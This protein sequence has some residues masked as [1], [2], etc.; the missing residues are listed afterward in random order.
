MTSR[1]FEQLFDEAVVDPL[2]KCGFKRRGK[3][4]KTVDFVEGVTLVS[5]LRLSGRFTVAGSAAW[6]LCFRH[7]FL[8]ELN[9]LTVP[10]E[11]FRLATEHYP[12]KFTPIELLEGQ[13]GLRYVAKL[14]WD[15]ERFTYEAQ[16]PDR[17]RNYLSTIA[18]FIAATFVPWARNHS[19]QLA[20]DQIRTFGTGRW[21]EKAWIDDYNQYLASN[22]A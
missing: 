11:P 22:L 6:T 18:T 15:H 14:N 9:E 20:R 1:E 4:G 17:V 5:L 10:T 12:F 21:D 13:R 16:S 2:G 3:N 19:P 8:R 7:T